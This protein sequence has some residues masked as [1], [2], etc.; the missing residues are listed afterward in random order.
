MAKEANVP[1]FFQRGSFAAGRDNYLIRWPWVKAKNKNL[2]R[3]GQKR[4][5]Y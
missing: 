1:S 2:M 3:V 5:K 4:K